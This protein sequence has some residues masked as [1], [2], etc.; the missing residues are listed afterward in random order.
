MTDDYI[1]RDIPEGGE[2]EPVAESRPQVVAY[3]GPT[4]DRVV[5]HGTIF[6]GELPSILQEK[7][8]ELPAVGGLIVP[9][10]QFAE[11]EL[12]LRQPGRYKMLFDLVAGSVKPR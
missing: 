9:F 1:T 8:K 7:I 10:D 11:V 3:L 2:P 4:I 6:R 5:S 12:Q